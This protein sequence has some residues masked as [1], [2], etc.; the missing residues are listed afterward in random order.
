MAEKAQ[1]TGT[2]PKPR[3]RSRIWMPALIIGLVVAACVGLAGQLLLQA[4]LRQSAPMLQEST[5]AGAA[6]VGS[7]IAAQFARAFELG[8][9]VDRLVGAESYMQRVVEGSP[10]VSGLALVDADGR[11]VTAT[12][13]DVRGEAFPVPAPGSSATLIVAPE[14]PLYDEALL[15]LQFSLAL[16]AIL[17]GIVAGVLTGSYIALS[18]EPARDRL[19]RSLERAAKGN[20]SRLY[21][22]ASRDRFSQATQ[23]LE[24]WIEKVAAAR[25]RLTEAVATIRAIDFDGSLG[26]RV[27][28][29]VEPLQDRYRLPEKRDDAVNGDAVGHT[30]IIGRIAVVIL[31]YAASFPLVANFAIDR[32]FDAISAGWA[33]VVP[34]AAEL[35]LLVLGTALGLSAGRFRSL[36][37]AGVLLLGLA[38]AA[39]FWCRTYELFVMLRACAGLAAGLAIAGLARGLP[40]FVLGRSMLLFVFAGL[41]VAPLFTGLIGEALGRRAAFLILG[42][43]TILLAP[44]L[45]GPS[46][47]TGEDETRPLGLNDWTLAAILVPAAPFLLIH[48]P[49]GVG[50]DNYLLGALAMATFGLS[51]PAGLK[52]PLSAALATVGIAGLA[53]A[54]S[55]VDARTAV[56]VASAA[57]GLAL[58]AAI[59]RI[60]PL[61]PRFVLLAGAS[62]TGL[63]IVGI[64]GASAILLAAGVGTAF[65][66]LATSHVLRRN[67]A[68][69][70]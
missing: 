13:D 19:V 27:D 20:F 5:D 69:G 53:I 23:A 50:Y 52:S 49:S 47:A 34:L 7:A 18:E 32:E 26:R 54:S 24:H 1:R 12:G 66:A 68:G 44:L 37:C 48:I 31:L 35:V 3:E 11:V 56:F 41:V 29:I 22:V 45:V 51:I 36:R 43:M 39:V 6:A 16:S 10:Q 30:G 55:W 40:R 63:A 58:G 2:V 38:T 60:M 17:A 59:G 62:V 57:L 28:E 42:V 65:L 46:A 33:P 64:T 8:I 25:S 4:G 14:S 61:P 67:S 15:R 9:P 21:P 70:A